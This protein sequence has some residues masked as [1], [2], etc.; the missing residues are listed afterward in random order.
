MNF[1]KILLLISMEISI[2]DLFEHFSSKNRLGHYSEFS[3]QNSKL[4][5]F[6]GPAF[7]C[8]LTQRSQRHHFQHQKGLSFQIILSFLSFFEYLY[9]SKSILS[10]KRFQ[11]TFSWPLKKKKK[12]SRKTKFFYVSSQHT[13]LYLPG[14]IHNNTIS[15]RKLLTH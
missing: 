10:K 7:P 1:K 15:P 11:K 5:N 4:A 3:C 14:W 9:F 8:K 13:H 12:K 6:V 2:L